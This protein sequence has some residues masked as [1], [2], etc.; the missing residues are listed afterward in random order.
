MKKNKKIQHPDKYEITGSAL[1]QFTLHKTNSMW[2]FR[3]REALKKK[4]GL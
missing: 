3:S 4:L 1:I 2:N